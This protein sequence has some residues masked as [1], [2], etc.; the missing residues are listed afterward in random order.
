MSNFCRVFMVYPVFVV[1][2]PFCPASSS[3]IYPLKQQIK[4]QSRANIQMANTDVKQT[5]IH[6]TKHRMV[7]ILYLLYRC[8]VRLCTRTFSAAFD[9]IWIFSVLRVVCFAQE[10][11]E[12]AVKGYMA[13]SYVRLILYM[14]I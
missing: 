9:P 5:F 13:V 8:S 2:V 1:S 12:R 14:N 6:K 11:T 7:E 3:P 4:I 10:M